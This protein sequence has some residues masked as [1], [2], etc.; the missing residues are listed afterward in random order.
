MTTYTAVVD[1]LVMDAYL[2]DFSSVLVI[3]SV[4][5]WWCREVSRKQY[6]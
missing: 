6:L 5:H 1:W 2:S 3:V 4:G